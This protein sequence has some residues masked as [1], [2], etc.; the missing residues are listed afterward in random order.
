MSPEKQDP[1][2][3]LKLPPYVTR[4][5][6]IGDGEPL[7]DVLTET[8][9]GPLGLALQTVT[10]CE[11]S[12]DDPK[13]GFARLGDL[14]ERHQNKALA[15]VFPIPG[16]EAPLILIMERPLMD[17]LLE[18]ALGEASGN[19]WD[20]GDRPITPLEIN[21]MQLLCHTMAPHLREALKIIPG[22]QASF[23]HVEKR[24]AL[25]DEDRK[26]GPAATLHFEVSTLGRSGAFSI[27]VPAAIQARFR[28]AAGST[29][30]EAREK[31][32]RDPIWMSHLK[33]EV[34]Q[35]PIELRATIRDKSFT[36][37]DIA[38]MKLGQILRLEAQ[39]DAQVLLEA[40][41]RPI[42]WCE[43]GRDGSNLT[44]RLDTRIDAAAGAE[45]FHPESFDNRDRFS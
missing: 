23:S 37:G 8:L 11:V 7:L 5:A 35:A 18:V 33:S 30:K 3:W 45:S 38:S 34:G 10:N 41:D 14:V 44:I 22:A 26:A 27:V 40:Q 19:R 43:L 6:V 29:L 24:L 15:G 16:W 31:A 17:G 42:F 9:P 39:A 25:L 36:L 21:F 28:A 4:R 20:S 1:P 13:Q 2:E 32:K 12:V